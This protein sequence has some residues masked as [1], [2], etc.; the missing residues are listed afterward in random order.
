[1]P[2]H[3]AALQ[4]TMTAELWTL[5]AI[6][7]IAMWVPHPI[8]LTVARCIAPVIAVHILVGIEDADS[9][10]SAIASAI[11]ALIACLIIFSSSFGESHAQAGA[12]G[13]EQRF[14]L[15]VPVSL[16]IPI[17]VAYLLLV[18]S[19]TFTPLWLVDRQWT[20]GGVGLV[21]GAALLW[22]VAPRM[23]Q[24][25]RRWLVFVPAGVVVHDPTMLSEVLMLRR[26][27]IVSMALA[28]ADTQAI[29]LTGFT[30]GVPL[31]VQLHE[32]VDVR[33]TP[34]AAR[35]LKTSD[36]LHVQAFLVAP[37]RPMQ[38]LTRFP[39]R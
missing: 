10:T 34:F 2:Q 35:I 14:L 8:S 32:M 33:L 16:L 12:Y 11:C 18:M 19:V 26:G 38:V 21:V 30:R 9:T 22:K 4:N 27:E 25:S 28:P 37:T 1:L 7:T 39:R 5:W 17:G 3:S 23:H 24:L 13:D 15:R 36:V 31:Q 20:L 29:D 6:V